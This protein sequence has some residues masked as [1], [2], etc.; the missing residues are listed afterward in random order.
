MISI[1]LYEGACALIRAPKS[2]GQQITGEC[3][4]GRAL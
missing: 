3:I 1:L 4:A 2:P